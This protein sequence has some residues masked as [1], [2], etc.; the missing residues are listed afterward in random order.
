M[1][2]KLISR[3]SFLGQASCAGVTAIPLLNTILNLKLAG[4]LAA[5]EPGPGEY[6]ALVC[7]FFSGGWDSFNVLVPRGAS[8]YAEYASVRQNLALAQGSLLPINPT[9]DPGLQLGL[10][11]ALPEVQTLFEAGDAAFVAN[12]G[13]LVEPVTKAQY[14]AGAGLPLGLFSHSDQQEQWQTSTPDAR[15]AVGW[16]GRMADLLK[17]LNSIDKVSMNISLSGNNVWQAG[18][19]VFDYSITDEGAVGPNGYNFKYQEYQEVTQPRSAA[20][21][22]QL[23]LHYS[24]LFAQAFNKSKKDAFDAYELFSASTSAALP[25]NPTFPNTDLGNQLKMVAKTIAGRTGLGATRQTFFVQY[26]GWDH[27]GELLTSQAAMLP[28]VSQAIGAFQNALTLMGV[29]DNVTLFTASDFGRT[30]TSNGQGSDH[31]W[32]GNQL[33]VG[34]AVNGKKIY[35]SYPDLALNNPLDLG[36]GRFIPTTSVDA[37]FAELALWLGVSKSSLPLVLPNISRFYDTNSVNWPLGF[38]A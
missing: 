5:A 8:E 37:Y 7:L 18:Q 25:G 38:L 1:N 14:F 17:Q 22:S 30:L 36:R 35:G 12:V 15:S 24:N 13:T 21:D 2:P 10:H 6:R 23:G 16:A 19:T 28:V 34:G 20:V 31:A 32:G 33:V 9:V 11:A 3:R 26:D 29:Q 4:S 27:H